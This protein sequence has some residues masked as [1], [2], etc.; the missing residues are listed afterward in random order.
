MFLKAVF[1]KAVLKA[2]KVVN[3]LKVVNIEKAA[4]AAFSTSIPDF[5]LS[6]SYP[7]TMIHPYFSSLRPSLC[8]IS[9]GLRGLNVTKWFLLTRPQITYNDCS[10]K[11][12]THG[13]CTVFS[14][15]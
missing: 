9:R 4:N 7:M 5:S 6:V 11:H 3:M 1:L 14:E 12:K 2:L 10:R 15:L 13:I 8:R